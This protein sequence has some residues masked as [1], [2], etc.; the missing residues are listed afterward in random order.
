MTQGVKDLI[1]AIASGDSLA[2]DAA[3]NS[4]M[5]SR[6]SE[7][8]DDMRV[9]VAQNM[10]ATESVQ[11]EELDEDA[12]DLDE[13]VESLDELSYKTIKS[14][15][16]KRHDQRWGKYGN[17]FSSRKTPSSINK[18]VKAKHGTLDSP[19]AKADIEKHNEKLDK[20]ESRHNKAMKAME[21][22]VTSDAPKHLQQYAAKTADQRKKDMEAKHKEEM[23]NLKRNHE[24]EKARGGELSSDSL[25]KLKNN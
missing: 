19:E 25:H 24:H 17:K 22:G 8:L 6:I 14:A 3:F 7:R 20:S 5:A 16:H 13:E 11:D 21:R 12:E 4:E 23:E 9:N 1:D 10:F 15:Y 2:I 18:K